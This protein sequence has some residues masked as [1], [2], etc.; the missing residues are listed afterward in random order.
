MTFSL[1]LFS[2]IDLDAVDEV[3]KVAY[4]VPYS[5]K[6]TLR[7]YLKL[8]PNGAFV[9]KDNNTVVGFGAALDYGSFAYIGLMSVH[10]S[11]QK[12]GVGRLLM[13]T[14]L[15]WLAERECQTVLLDANQAGAPLYLQYG[16]VEDDRTLDMRQVQNI[17]LPHTHSERVSRLKN[18]DFAQ[19]VAFDTPYFGTSREAL[20]ARYYADDPQR[21][22]VTHGSS[23]AITGFLIAQTR[24]IGPFVARSVEDAEQLLQ[25]ALTLAYRAE[26]IVFVS[27]HNADA[28]ALLAHY[29]F[30]QA[31]SLHHMR[32]GLPVERGRATTLYGQASLGFG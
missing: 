22:F 27:A 16:F 4:N 17:V 29:G 23:G 3:I 25:Q 6:D 14:L 15:T 19:L 21:V 13:D 31:R 28:F 20:L 10:P 24:T 1:H 18:T 7:H 9:V 30:T 12:R 26:P 32:K 2:E 5:R 8:Q 11:V